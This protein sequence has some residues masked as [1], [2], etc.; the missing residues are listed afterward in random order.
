MPATDENPEI[1]LQ[2]IRRENSLSQDSLGIKFE[3][4]CGQMSKP[5]RFRNPK[6]PAENPFKRSEVVPKHLIASDPRASKLVQDV[7]L[8][9]TL[10][11]AQDFLC[12]AKSSLM[13][14][15]GQNRIFHHLLLPIHGS[16][17]VEKGQSQRMAPIDNT[18][19]RV[20]P[21][22]LTVLAMASRKRRMHLARSPRPTLE[23]RSPAYHCRAMP[24]V[25]NMRMMLTMTASSLSSTELS[26]RSRWD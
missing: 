9:M 2:M 24:T 11:S 19:P 17:P 15:A 12:T 23:A 16:S 5:R 3:S 20:L 13:S 4:S 8:R 22:A 14:I 7:V 10:N 1:W 6:Q 18:L 21:D 25:D 26:A